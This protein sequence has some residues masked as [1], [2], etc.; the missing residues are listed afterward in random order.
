VVTRFAEFKL[1][2]LNRQSLPPVAGVMTEIRG[3][4]AIFDTC[5]NSS[6]IPSPSLD[7]QLLLRVENNPYDV[8]GDWCGEYHF[9][10]GRL[11]DE[12]VLGSVVVICEAV[13][14][15]QQRLDVPAGED[16][17]RNVV[18]RFRDDGTNYLRCLIGKLFHCCPYTV[19]GAI[20]S[21]NYGTPK[22]TQFLIYFFT[23][24]YYLFHVSFFCSRTFN[25]FGFFLSPSYDC[26]LF[27]T[28]L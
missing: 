16:V 1:A 6:S 9:L 15:L 14:G 7:Y 24:L 3:E 25:C 13:P 21:R 17:V 4:I 10:A 11:I 2:R 27:C 20:Y 18:V 8:L 5:G 19:C 26:K 12:D 28:T 22:R 23:I